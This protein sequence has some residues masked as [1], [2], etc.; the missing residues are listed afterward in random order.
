MHMG[1]GMGRAYR[2]DGY[3]H[4]SQPLCVLNLCTFSHLIH[5]IFDL[6]TCLGTMQWEFLVQNHCD[7]T[8]LSHTWPVF[9]CV[10]ILSLPRFMRA[11][12]HHEGPPLTTL[13]NPN[14]FPKATPPKPVTLGL[15][16]MNWGGAHNSVHSSLWLLYS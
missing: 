1:V 13:S 4:M 9:T 12:I 2:Y 10:P 15:P 14:H 11:L 3:Q 5:A 8:G 7:V 16:H 6:R